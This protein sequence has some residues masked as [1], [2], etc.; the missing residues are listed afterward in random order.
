MPPV[1]ALGGTTARTAAYNRA[2][3]GDKAGEKHES[4]RIE[5]RRGD[6]HS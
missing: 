5:R 3:L 4:G 2:M 1:P 6:I